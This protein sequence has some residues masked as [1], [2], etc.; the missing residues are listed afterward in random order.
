MRF[1]W[2]WLVLGVLVVGTVAARETKR[3][4]DAAR[5]QAQRAAQLAQAEQQRRDSIASA[6]TAEQPRALSAEPATLGQAYATASRAARAIYAA[7][8]AEKA[9]ALGR[10]QK[11]AAALA[12]VRTGL[13]ALEVE[14][15]QAAALVTM[16]TH[17]E[18]A[19]RLLDELNAALESNP[20]DFATV[21]ARARDIEAEMLAGDNARRALVGEPRPPGNA[22]QARDYFPQQYTRVPKKS[23]A[24]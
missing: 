24:R 5:A 7:Q 10:A 4:R 23:P 1:G 9:S 22:R 12:A 2:I 20:P 3:H 8:F 18:S 15:G 19:V 16:R 11:L 17:S 13:D 6:T 14:S 21:N